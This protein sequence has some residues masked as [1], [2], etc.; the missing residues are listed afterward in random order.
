MLS[1]I[2]STIICE[3]FDKAN[4]RMQNN[5]SPKRGMYLPFTTKIDYE[6]EEGYRWKDLLLYAGS[7]YVG[8]YTRDRCDIWKNGARTF[9]MTLWESLGYHDCE[10]R[11]VVDRFLFVNSDILNGVGKLSNWYELIEINSDYEATLKEARAKNY[12]SLYNK[13]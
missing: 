5:H 2:I 9:D 3:T 13:G 11:G 7:N 1:T 10:W 12:Q 8:V 4:L 6:N